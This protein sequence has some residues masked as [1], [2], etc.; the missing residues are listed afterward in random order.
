MIG[1]RA[2]LASMT[3]HLFVILSAGMAAAA[4]IAAF[5]ATRTSDRD[6]ERQLL[7]RTADRVEGS[8]SFL[9]AVPEPI[10]NALLDSGAM[11]IRAQPI[12]LQG[13]RADVDFEN[14]LHE[15]GGTL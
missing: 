10:R 7:E 12:A 9:E 15:R 8:V 14:V 4:L 6:F 3:G 13:L 1:I 5:V 2:F 11:G